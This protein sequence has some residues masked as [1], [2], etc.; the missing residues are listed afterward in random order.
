MKLWTAIDRHLE[1]TLA[2]VLFTAILALGSEQVFSRYA[3]KVVH[4][5]TEELM[6]ILFVALT[7]VSF[8]LCAKRRQHVKV[9]ILD[10]LLPPLG[11]K[12]LAFFSAVVFL[13]F[14]LLVAKYALDITLLQYSTQQTTAAMDFPTWIYFALGPVFFVLLALRILQIEI[15]PLFKE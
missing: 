3:F 10:L 5:W 2:V 13:A 1:E 11:K 7:L 12:I 9:E 15:L 8:V 6:R 4:S 14:S